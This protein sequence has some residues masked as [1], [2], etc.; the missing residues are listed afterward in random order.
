M[1]MLLSGLREAGIQMIVRVSA[2]S[3]MKLVQ[4]ARKTALA[5]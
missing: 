4:A 2:T 5:V 3:T 1:D